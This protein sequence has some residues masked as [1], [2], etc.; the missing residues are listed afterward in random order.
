MLQLVSFGR[1]LHQSIQSETTFNFSLAF[2][3]LEWIRQLLRLPLAIEA[4]SEFA[5]ITD[6]FQELEKS[7]SLTSGLGLTD[8]WRTWSSGVSLAPSNESKIAMLEKE[9]RRLLH[10]LGNIGA[11]LITNIRNPALNSLS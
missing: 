2:A 7:M 9:S 4:S 6:S 11:Y 8:L 5:T 1:F 10:S 3:T